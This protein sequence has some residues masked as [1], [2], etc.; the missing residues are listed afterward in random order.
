MD[1][2]GG[3][4]A[5]RHTDLFPSCSAATLCRIGGGSLQHG[6]AGRGPSLRAHIRPDE[7]SHQHAPPVYPRKIWAKSSQHG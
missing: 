7:S 4:V 3:P 2:I 5:I 1:S 6:Q